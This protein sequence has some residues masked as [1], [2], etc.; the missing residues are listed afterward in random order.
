MLDS[1]V[2]AVVAVYLGW[3]LGRQELSGRKSKKTPKPHAQPQ[4]PKNLWEPK[5]ITC[6][7]CDSEQWVESSSQAFLCSDCQKN[8]AAFGGH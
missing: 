7:E 3:M 6:A 5:K 2:L 4:I 8:P 1:I